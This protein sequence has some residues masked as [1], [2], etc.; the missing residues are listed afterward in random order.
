M[1]TYTEDTDYYQI[2]GDD[3]AELRKAMTS[4]SPSCF[5]STTPYDACTTWHI[6]WR[7]PLN[8]I[9][10]SCE[11][12]IAI[13]V[14]IDFMYP[15]WIDKNTADVQL[16]KKWDAYITNLNI[17]EEGHKTLAV[18]TG[19]KLA[20]ILETL[21]ANYNCTE[22]GLIANEKGNELLEELRSDNLQY[23]NQ[24][25]HGATQGATFP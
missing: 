22:L 10:T 6:S 1:I 16:R 17:H 21:S 12:D 4:N 5:G 3:E 2:Y 24:T 9:A 8:E 11:E 25:K 19:T 15:D 7:V 18:K 13:S 20:Q 23:D 14:D